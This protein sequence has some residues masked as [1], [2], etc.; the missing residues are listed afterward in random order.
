MSITR[1]LSVRHFVK[2]Q[3]T[4]QQPERVMMGSTL[5]VGTQTGLLIPNLFCQQLIRKVHPNH[6]IPFSLGSQSSRS[7]K[8]S[9]QFTQVLSK[10]HAG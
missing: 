10:R 9:V 2:K 3:T 6:A 4:M 5:H 8:L 7:K 1:T